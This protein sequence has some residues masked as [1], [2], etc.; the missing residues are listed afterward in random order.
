MARSLT[1]DPYRYCRCAEQRSSW[2]QHGWLPWGPKMQASAACVA[3]QLQ[4]AQI[5]VHR[6]ALEYKCMRTS[7]R[8]QWPWIQTPVRGSIQIRHADP[9]SRKYQKLNYW[10]LFEEGPR[11]QMFVPSRR[12][13]QM[14]IFTIVEGRN[15]IRR[16][17]SCSRHQYSNW[18]YVFTHSVSYHK[19]LHHNNE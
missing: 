13:V 18:T 16:I 1:G 2:R 4:Q 11:T 7:D 3:L 12:R 14:Q 10:S 6:H 17:C 5:D 9:F 15:Q 8:G 19:I